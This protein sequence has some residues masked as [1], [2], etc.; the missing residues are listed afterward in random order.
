MYRCY[1]ALLAVVLVLGCHQVNMYFIDFGLLEKFVKEH[2]IPYEAPKEKQELCKAIVNLL[3]EK[4]IS[5]LTQEMYDYLDSPDTVNFRF[6]KNDFRGMDLNY[7]LEFSQETY[8]GA[9][10][11]SI[12]YDKDKNWMVALFIDGGK[13][14]NHIEITAPSF[15]EKIYAVEKKYQEYIEEGKRT[16]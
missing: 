11:L 8:F 5:A 12:Q 9:T 15:K 6:K 16:M 2:D 1:V 10:Y 7:I 4:K 14:T 13:N 3:K